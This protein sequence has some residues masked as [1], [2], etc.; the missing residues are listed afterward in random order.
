MIDTDPSPCE[1]L[2][3]VSGELVPAA[4]MAAL[5]RLDPLHRELAVTNMLG[6]ARRWLAHAVV[7]TE[8]RPAAEF[9]AMVASIA[10]VT[11][12]FGLSKEI[13]IDAVKMVYRA[14]RGVGVAIRGGQANG[15]VVKSGDVGGGGRGGDAAAATRA[16][17][18][19]KLDRPTNFATAG[20][21]SNNGTGIYAMT[22]DVS[23]AQF[24]R[25]LAEAENEG[26]LSR[27]NVV[28]K[29]KKQPAPQGKQPAPQGKRHE[30]LKGTRHHDPA[31][32]VEETAI[33]LAGIAMGLD[34]IAPGTVPEES[35]AAHTEVMRTA[36][37]KIRKFLNSEM[38]L[39]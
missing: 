4:N 39:S 18:Y 5:E 10:E 22:D 24:E 21:L 16:G 35:K 30:L 8:P 38:S 33:S 36:L 13:Q 25:A 29:I 9:K 2:P 11:K 34:L 19:Q 15:S 1:V 26:D 14:E 37:S 23:D 7:A 3:P 32:I 12:Q 31:R 28:R 27:A 20:E 17:Y 6:E